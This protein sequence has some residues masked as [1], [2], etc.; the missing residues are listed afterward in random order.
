MVEPFPVNRLG[1]PDPWSLLPPRD[2]WREWKAQ[3]QE[4][5]ADV[6]GPGGH[7]VA[8]PAVDVKALPPS[9]EDADAADGDR[10][11]LSPSAHDQAR[12]RPQGL[13]VPV[14]RHRGHAA[15]PG[16]GDGYHLHP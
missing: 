5:A 15:E 16:L 4:G 3:L 2:G 1:D 7:R 11:A 14:A 9:R 8:Q 13:S 6:F 12:A 10:G